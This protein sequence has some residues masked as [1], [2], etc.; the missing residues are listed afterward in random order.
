[1]HS[2]SSP[3][4]GSQKLEDTSDRLVRVDLMKALKTKVLEEKAELLEK[5]KEI[6]KQLNELLSDA[7][8]QIQQ[9]K[10]EDLARNDAKALKVEMSLVV[11]RNSLY[12]TWDDDKKE[13]ILA[14]ADAVG[15]NAGCC[16]EQHA[17]MEEGRLSEEK[18]IR[19]ES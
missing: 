11:H 16:W 13:G 18:R 2:T 14:I 6:D 12:K 5:E 17:S 19:E 4:T 10:R 1:M 8:T 15:K 7:F 9:R 3:D